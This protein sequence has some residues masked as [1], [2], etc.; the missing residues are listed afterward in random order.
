M[1]ALPSGGSRV[2]VPDSDSLFNANCRFQPGSSKLSIFCDTTTPQERENCEKERFVQFSIIIILVRN[3]SWTLLP[4]E[5][6]WKW[7]KL[8]VKIVK[9]NKHTNTSGNSNIVKLKSFFS[10]DLVVWLIIFSLFCDQF[11]FQTDRRHVRQ[12]HLPPSGFQTI[13]RSSCKWQ[14]VNATGPKKTALKICHNWHNL[15]AT[16]NLYRKSVPFHQKDKVARKKIL[17]Q[18][19]KYFE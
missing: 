11:Y 2:N 6:I 10:S 17:N 19:K 1:E 7:N 13:T 9:H 8:P 16:E 4:F 15:T 12:P 5:W 18:D 3:Q 14:T